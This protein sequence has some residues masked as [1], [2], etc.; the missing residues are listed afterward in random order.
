ALEVG[1]VYIVPL[2]ESL[3]LGQRVSGFANPKSSTG[4]LNLF[5]RLIV[6]GAEQFDVVPAGYSGPLYAEL[7]PNAFSVLARAGDRLNQLRFRRGQPGLAD[8]ALQRLHREVG[9]VGDGGGEPAQIRKGLVFTV[10]LGG[11][12]AERLAGFKA[13]RHAGVVDLS[14]VD[15]Y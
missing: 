8:S 9:L 3:A 5:T 4:R 10:D 15:R 14:A 2:A 1:C 12:G 7:A 13:K 6:D 11:L